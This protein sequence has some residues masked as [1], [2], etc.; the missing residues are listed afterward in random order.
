[1]ST[2]SLPLLNQNAFWSVWLPELGDLAALLVGVLRL[3]RLDDTGGLRL[4]DELAV[5]RVVDRGRAAD[6][7]AVVVDRLAALRREELL[8]R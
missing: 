5:E 1:L 3:H 8:D 7:L 4:A 6:D 2:A